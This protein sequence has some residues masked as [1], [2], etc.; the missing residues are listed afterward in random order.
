VNERGLAGAP[1]LRVVVGARRHVTI[2]RALRFLGVGR[3]AL[4]VVECDAE[5]RM[6]T[7]ALRAALA[8]AG[9]PAIVCAQA[10]E[11]NTGA[12]DDLAAAAD[13]AS[14][15][16]A[17][18]HVDGAFGLW[19]G[20]S[21]T[22][23]HHLL[24][25]ERADSWATDAHKWLNVPYDCGLAFT[26]HP[27][28]H[29]AAMAARA[30]YLEQAAPGAGRDPSDW[31]PE[32]SRRARGFALW[33]ALRSLGRRGIADLVERC[34]EHARRF[35]RELAALEGCEVLNEVVLNQVL[36][37]FGDDGSTR[38]VV[39]RVQQGGE[40]WMGGTTVDGRAAMRISVVNWRTTGGD[41]ARAVRAL[42]EAWAAVRAG[43]S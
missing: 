31:A 23:R 39:R 6:R 26:A 34:C 27:E 25:S 17:W 10:G 43:R 14:D 22:L 40:A 33:A 19:A 20:A 36:V 29:R 7:E 4:E 32:L 41:V 9:G 1:P 16:G 13:L 12:F 15:A 30:G 8:R 28:A 35:A 42:R 11:V 5:G 18:L 21:P 37:R 3:A 38:E 24:G 2:D